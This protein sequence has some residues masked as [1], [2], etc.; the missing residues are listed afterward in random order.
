M[1]VS[2]STKI[3]DGSKKSEKS[4]FFRGAKGV[5]LSALGVQNLVEITLSLMVIEINDIFHFCQN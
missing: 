2:I 3:Q 4:Q 1:S 5:V